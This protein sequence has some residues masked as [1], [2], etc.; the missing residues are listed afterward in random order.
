MVGN[1]DDDHEN[2][3]DRENPTDGRKRHQLEP[4]IMEEL[5]KLSFDELRGR[6]VKYGEYRRLT[7]EDRFELGKAYFAYQHQVY[8][9]ICQRK[10]H[11]RPALSHL[12]LVNRTRGPTNFNHYCK[13]DAVASITYYDRKFVNL[14]IK[15]F[16]LLIN[17]NPFI[18]SIDYN[19]RMRL[20]GLLWG[21]VDNATKEKWK[22]SDFVKSQIE[23]NNHAEHSTQPHGSVPGSA[24]SPSLP[25]SRFK[26]N[27][28]AP[29]FAC[30]LQLRHLSTAHNVEG[31]VVLTSRDPES[32]ILITG[33]SLLGQQFIDMMAQKPPNPCR[34]FFSFVSGYVAIQETSG[35][36]PPPP[37]RPTR[38]ARG[39]TDEK[40]ESYSKGNKPLNVDAVRGLLANALNKATH[41]TSNKGWPGTHTNAELK[42]LGV[43]LKV[44]SNSHGVTPQDFCGRPSDMDKDRLK[45]I[46][47]AF[48]EGWVE[49]T[50]PP[51]PESNEIGGVL[52]DEDSN[53]PQH[54]H[55]RNSRTK[56]TR[57]K[58]QNRNQSHK[59]CTKASK[60]HLAKP[61]ARKRLVISDSDDDAS[62]P[63][64]PKQPATKKQRVQAQED[65]E[66]DSSIGGS[67]DR[68]FHS[69]GDGGLDDGILPEV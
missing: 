27:E 9:I 32:N 14:I 46:L 30:N 40:V 3:N 26:L 2:E 47:C 35:V 22:D 51:A 25:K 18:D 69:D 38:Q 42:R 6:A 44:K 68:L 33:G 10:L 24:V 55:A 61:T 8:K 50:G 19:E 57:G 63:S 17:L 34:N 59:A 28:W 43:V 20:C 62:Q 16:L 60:N 15:D 49:L 66:E 56:K 12:G 41:G 48:G 45:R 13:Y 21:E 23:A 11:V 7:A 1:Q 65:I 52:E 58:Q 29:N 36:E 5:S 64:S 39:V 54:S 67:D 31:F 37:V 4:E 53:M